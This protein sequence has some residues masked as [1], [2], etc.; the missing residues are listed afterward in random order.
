M[1]CTKRFFFCQKSSHLCT[2]PWHQLAMFQ[3]HCSFFCPTK[4]YS[5][6][7]LC[8][9]QC[10]CWYFSNMYF[11]SQHCYNVAPHFFMLLLCLGLFCAFLES[12]LW[13]AFAQKCFTCRYFFWLK[14]ELQAPV[15]F[16]LAISCL[17]GRRFN[18][19]SHGASHS[20]RPK[21][22]FKIKFIV[23]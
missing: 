2:I 7:Q 15:R 14:I 4:F 18:Q 5:Q 1:W 3:A 6:T 23:I 13:I 9:D 20:N 16:E 19:L 22:I 11:V 21:I 8:R 10:C 17:L 12:Q